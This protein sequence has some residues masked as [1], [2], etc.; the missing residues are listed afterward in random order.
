M[1]A[2]AT[3]SSLH[4]LSPSKLSAFITS[5]TMFKARYVLGIKLQPSA[6]MVLGRAFHNALELLGRCRQM[7]LP[8]GVDDLL[9]EFNVSFAEM[10][11]WKSD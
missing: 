4:Q 2:T 3:R 6:S 5:P 9:T 8:V 10:V 7:D 1:T 11:A